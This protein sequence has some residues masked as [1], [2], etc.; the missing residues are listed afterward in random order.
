MSVYFQ[1]RPRLPLPR[2]QPCFCRGLRTNRRSVGDEAVKWLNGAGLKYREP[3]LK[4]HGSSWL[5]GEHVCF[6]RSL[7]HPAVEPITSPFQ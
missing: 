6:L 2:H 4:T 7:Y 1:L 3:V 5:G